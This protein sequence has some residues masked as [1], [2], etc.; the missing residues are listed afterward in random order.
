M[1]DKDPISNL[2]KRNISFYNYTEMTSLLLSIFTFCLLA[3]KSQFILIFFLQGPFRYHFRA[4]KKV[5]YQQN[6]TKYFII[7][8]FYHIFAVSCKRRWL[9]FLNRMTSKICVDCMLFNYVLLSLNLFISTKFLILLFSFI[10][11]FASNSKNWMLKKIFWL[12][13][14]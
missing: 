3:P 7:F 4:W 6:L 11:N 8:F 10:F 5:S 14:V 13:V 2:H 12:H 1:L 9:Q